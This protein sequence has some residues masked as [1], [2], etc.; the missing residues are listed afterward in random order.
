MS[1]EASSTGLRRWQLTS[2]D[3]APPP[4]E[5]QF[6]SAAFE[7][8]LQQLRDQA[9]NQGIASGHVAGQAV[10]YQAGYEHGRIK[11]YEDGQA[12][13]RAEAD[14]VAAVA[15]AFKTAIDGTE[16]ALSDVLIELALDIA[17][18][19]VRQHIQQDKAAL[20]EPARELL[21]AE[22]ALAGAPQLIV[23]PTD[24]PTVETYLADELTARGWTVRTDP[25]IEP[26]GC[27]AQAGSGEAD[28]SLGTRWERV[29]AA[30]GKVSTW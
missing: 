12:L 23:S 8:E 4:P 26:G 22:P 10:G 17:R 2:F 11:G 19:V 16:T 24:L 29:A 30:L 13:G 9:H 18:Q 15:T 25:S 6:D 20:I 3:P 1:A 28:A 27:R 21:R 5:P 7:A 14:R